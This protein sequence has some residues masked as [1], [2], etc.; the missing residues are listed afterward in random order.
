MKNILILAVFLFA[1]FSFVGCSDD[2]VESITG[3]TPIAGERGDK[4]DKGDK[5]E[6]GDKGE[7]GDDSSVTV[8]DFQD[9]YQNDS[10]HVDITKDYVLHTCFTEGY[11]LHS[12]VTN[13]WGIAVPIDECRDADGY[14]PSGKDYGNCNRHQDEHWDGL[15]RSGPASAYTCVAH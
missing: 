8:L 14:D 15:G 6:R 1:A 5:G 13:Q 9:Y 12:G 7:D 10:Q 2:P 3:P 11:H 4:G